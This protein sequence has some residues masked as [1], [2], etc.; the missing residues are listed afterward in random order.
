MTEAVLL[1][2]W[3]KRLAAGAAIFV[4]ALGLTVLAGWFSH[5]P[6]LFQI[7]P[8]LPPMTRNAAACFVLSGLALLLAALGS[9]RRLV[10]VCAALVSVVSLLTISEYVFSV[11]PGIDELLGP[12]YIAFKMSSPGRMSPMGAICFALASMGLVMALRSR[13]KRSALVLGVNGSIIAA[14]GMATSMGF[15]LG[16]SDT[17]GWGNLTRLALHTAVGFWV[18]GFGMVAL[19]WHAETDPARTP[20]W[21]PISVA[22]GV[23]TGTAGLWE[24]LVAGGQA[25]F[26]LI[27]A[28]ALAGGCLMAAVFGLTVYLAQR[29]H[30][31][32]VELQRA[33]RSLEDHI[34][35]RADGERRISL[36]LNQGRWARGAIGQRIRRFGQQ[37]TIRYSVRHAASEWAQE[38]SG[39]S[40]LRTRALFTRFRGCHHDWHI[41]LECRIPRAEHALWKR[42]GR[43]D[44]DPR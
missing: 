32:T 7:L 25:P 38:R 13:S 20:R 16:S 42:P 23:A 15:G 28:V 34:I 35:Q 14:V 6:T 27:P 21:L 24:A 33:N 31:Q 37:G 29:A 44:R 40:C 5:T 3:P 1:R 26:A 11:N 18:L 43:V 4:I 19:A 22:L 39:V 12:S 17:F 10:A 41:R 8:Q 36:A 9:G 2:P 30:A